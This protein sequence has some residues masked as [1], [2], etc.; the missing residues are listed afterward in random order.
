MITRTIVTVSGAM[1]AGLLLFNVTSP[2]ADNEDGIVRF[3]SAYPL[4]ETV[5]HF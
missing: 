2:R 1:I 3:K 5:N 4:T